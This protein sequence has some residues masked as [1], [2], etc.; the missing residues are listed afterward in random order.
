MGEHLFRS[1]IKRRLFVGFSYKPEINE[2]KRQPLN[3]KI[4][5]LVGILGR[6]HPSSLAHSF[7][8]ALTAV[9]LASELNLNTEVVKEIFVGSLLHDIGKTGVP[10][11]ILDRKDTLTTAQ[12]AKLI[13]HGRLGA[14]IMKRVGLADL[15]YFCDEH[16][17]G[18][19]NNHSWTEEELAKRHPLTE[20]IT[21]SDLI[22]AALDPRRP[23][24]SPEQ[25]EALIPDIE[26]KEKTGIFSKNLVSAFKRAMSSRFLFP[27]YTSQIYHESE[28]FMRLVNEFGLN[29]SLS[30]RIF[31]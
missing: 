19:S 7:E 29:R 9:T 6:H 16:H 20:I 28:L 26:A 17:I 23:Y 18:N 14:A 11:E 27:P 5:G 2:L 10:V 1:S 25:L 22:C 3:E 31:L 12:T 15:A 21:L 8:V 30:E 13:L 24:H 4:G